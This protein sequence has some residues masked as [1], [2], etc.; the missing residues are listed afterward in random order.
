[1]ADINLLLQ[2]VDELKEK[3]DLH[4][5]WR[6]S[7][8][9]DAL[10][11]EYTYDSNRIEGNTLTLRETDLVIHKGLTVGGKP[12]NEHLEAINHYEAIQFISD[13]VKSN[14]R[15]NLHNLLS[16]HG[17]ILHGID[18][19]NAGRFRQV[20]VMISGSRHIPPQ[21]WQID[22]LMEDYF[23]FYQQ[24]KEVS[25]SVI[26]AAELHERLATIHPFIDGNGRTARLVMNLILLQA[27][28]PIANIS[29]ETEARLAYYNALE[30]CNV[31]QDK[32]AFHTLIV[33]YVIESLERLLSLLGKPNKNI[34]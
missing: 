28:Y 16:I 7:E 19:G 33:S 15:F 26:L 29:G 23:L 2:R 31:E 21:P 5:D 12:M 9:L 18:R 30:K 13:L 3:L 8:I 1:M 4:R 20:P 27:G 10:H 25:H 22:K 11:I 6:K 17:L 34:I 32:T 14:E 24:N